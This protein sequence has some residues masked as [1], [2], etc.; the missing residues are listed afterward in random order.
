LYNF[1]LD[2]HVPVDHVL[3]AIDR[4]VDLSELRRDF[5]LF[6]SSIVQ[7]TSALLIRSRA[8]AS[9]HETFPRREQ[10]FIGYKP[11]DYNN[12]HDPDHLVHCRELAI[13]RG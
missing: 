10:Y 8:P 1:L 2:A 13:E 12:Q 9:V 11:D 5:A 4:F 3:S 7:S 6:Y